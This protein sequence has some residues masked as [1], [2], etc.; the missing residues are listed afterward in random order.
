M[1]N[2]TIGTVVQYALSNQDAQLINRRRVL[3]N[4]GH[5]S[6]VYRGEQFPLEI[7]RIRGSIEGGGYIVDGRV[8]LGHD[9]YHVTSVT[10]GRGPGTW[11]A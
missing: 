8:V 1:T 3:A 9:D 5:S 11:C 10:Y 6:L 2:P 7:T 4:V